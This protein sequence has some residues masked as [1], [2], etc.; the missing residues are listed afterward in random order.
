MNDF[1]NDQSLNNISRDMHKNYN[2]ILLSDNE[3]KIL[4]NY[5]FNI[6]NYNN[7]KDLIFDLEESLNNSPNEELE[8]VLDNLSEFD[9]YHN[10][11]K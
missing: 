4:N 6:N 10:T 2:G 7:I 8:N 5:G 3:V 11:N 9:Y 1:N